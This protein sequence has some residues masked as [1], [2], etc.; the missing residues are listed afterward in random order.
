M[1]HKREK[2]AFK[3]QK[4]WIYVA[5]FALLAGV[6]SKAGILTGMQV[7][8]KEKKIKVGFMEQADFAQES[9]RH[10]YGYGV[11]YLERIGEYTGWEY[12]FVYDTWENCMSMTKSGEID[13]LCMVQRTPEREK[14]YLYTSVP[15]GYEYTIVY[16]KNDSDIYYMD[17]EVMN[18]KRVGMMT[19]SLHSKEMVSHAA[20][21]GIEIEEVY[22]DSEQM[23]LDAL[24]DGS[25]DIAAVG[26]LYS[27]EN[28]KIVDRFGTKAIYCITGKMNTQLMEEL[29]YALQRLKVMEPAVEAELTEKYYG[30]ASISDSPMFTRQEA[31]YIEKAEPVSVK[32]MQGS[33]PLSYIE[34]GEMDGVFVDYLNLLSEKSGLEF[35]IEIVTTPMTMEE[36]TQHIVE[37]DYLMLRAE[38]ALED[39]DLGTEIATSTILLE[40]QLSYVK[41]KETVLKTGRDDLVFAITGEMGYLPPLLERDVP[42]CIIKYYNSTTDCLEAVIKGD[43]D[44]AIQDA[45]MIT[46]LLQKPR[47]ADN[48]VEYP[49]KVYTNGM[50]LFGS[51]E[52]Q[53]LIDIINKTIS[54][55]S[56]EEKSNLVSMELISNPY[57]QGITDFLYRYQRWIIFSALCVIISVTVYTVLL[58]RITSLKFERKEYELLRKKNKQ[59]ELT[60]V[61]NRA[62]FYEEARKMID[63]ST[64]EMCI[65][66]MDISNFKVVNDLYGMSTGDKLLCYMAEELQELVYGRKYIL[67]RFNGDH[68]Y[69]CLA[70]KDFEE[71]SLPKRFKTFLDEI[72]IKAIYGVFMIEDQKELPVNI[73][74]DRA[75]LAA[76]DNSRQ[77]SEY[78]RFYSDEERKRIVRE[79]EIENDMEKALETRQFCVFVQPKYDI[80]RDKIIGGEA[81]V[82]WKHPQKGMIPPGLFIGIFEKNGFIVRLDYYVWEET[83][84]VIAKLKKLGYENLPISINVSRAHFYGKEL[85][86][87]LAEL[88]G[89]YQLKP[90]DI[91]LE[92]TE[93]ICAEDTD[94]IYKRIKELRSDG[95]KVAMDD[96]GSGYSSL[97]M[98]KEVPLDII[99]MDLK[100]LDGGED[101]EKGRFILH[102]LIDLAKNMQLQVIVEGVETKEQVQFLREIGSYYVQ[103][104]YYS[105]PVDIETYENMLKQ[106]KEDSKNSEF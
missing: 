21:E 106:E 57:D 102:T 96:F 5:L 55:I 8:A 44:V 19:G 41:H 63:E 76:H 29:D 101:V 97:N 37:G 56:E 45:Y 34:D 71:I 17:H 30:M 98:L 10:F 87:K 89:K 24:Q 62:C 14:D 78:I 39:S 60:G 83:C 75:N 31:E 104:Y 35:E 15:F 88:I 81:L 72:D 25:V 59:D 36:Q 64:E 49:G 23:A 67:A 100:F 22:F 53:L 74:C 105:K 33:K 16:A 85:R 50:C 48:L 42:N 20:E 9:D 82:R 93:T 69:M 70:K 54:Y 11:E 80:S 95:F 6:L 51:A 28:V 77:R 12:E 52:N 26:S 47:Y 4:L 2:K 84:R 27:H 40:T 1:K 99:K 90:D 94:I 103:G 65:L 38:S 18:G 7:N 91:E 3:Y 58:R 13:L 66:M 61:Y 68:F 32:L 73:M 46:Y 92:I 79:T 43:A 86:D